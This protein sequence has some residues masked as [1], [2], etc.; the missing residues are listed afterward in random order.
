VIKVARI[1]VRL[2]FS[3][4]AIDESPSPIARHPSSKSS[5]CEVVAVDVEGGTGLWDRLA[6]DHGLRLCVAL[7]PYRG[8]IAD[9]WT[10]SAARLAMIA[11]TNVLTAPTIRREKLVGG[12][13]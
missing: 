10:Y 8:K 13:D 1:D 4:S 2:T 3:G 9:G 12:S 7:F 11:G 5:V 6:A